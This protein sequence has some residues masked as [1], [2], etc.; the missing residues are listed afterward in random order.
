MKELI[1][2]L[3]QKAGQYDEYDWH[4]VTELEAADALERMVAELADVTSMYNRCVDDVHAARVERDSLQEGLD[5]WHARYL[6]CE[7]E[8]DVEKEHVRQCVANI[9]NLRALLTSQ[10]SAYD[11]G[12]QA[13]REAMRQECVKH[14]DSKGFVEDHG[15][16]F[17]DEIRSLK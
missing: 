10:S 9:A 3:R 5:G 7:V 15:S 4:S 8:R 16:N 12:Y 2:R 11:S 6:D 14:F 1:E 13:G 17:A